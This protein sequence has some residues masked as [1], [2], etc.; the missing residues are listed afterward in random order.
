MRR[1]R[2]GLA[3]RAPAGPPASSSASGS[4]KTRASGRPARSAA[5]CASLWNVG[6]GTRPGHTRTHTHT[7]THRDRRIR[8]SSCHSANTQWAVGAILIAR[9]YS[10][11]KMGREWTMEVVWWC[12]VMRRLRKRVNKYVNKQIKSGTLSIFFFLKKCVNKPQCAPPP[13]NTHTH[14]HTHPYTRRCN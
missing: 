8:V 6:S 1:A 13:P 14:T 11:R 12:D 5:S 7:H 2:W 10:A 3:P 9:Q 4:G